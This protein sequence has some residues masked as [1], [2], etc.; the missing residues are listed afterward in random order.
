M[1]SHTARGRDNV[2]FYRPVKVGDEVSFYATLLRFGRTSMQIHVQAWRRRR[3]SDTSELVTEATFASW[4]L[5]R[6]G[7]HGRCSWKDLNRE[8]MLLP[9]GQTVLSPS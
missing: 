9:R 2:K 5:M 7:D 4:R 8:V 1:G 6:K 3:D